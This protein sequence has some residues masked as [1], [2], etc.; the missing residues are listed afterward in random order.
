MVMKEFWELVF[1][2]LLRL[3]KGF[4]FCRQHQ[5]RTLF[6][7]FVFPQPLRKLGAYLILNHERH[8]I[9]SWQG[10]ERLSSEWWTTAFQR[11]YWIVHLKTGPTW[12]I[13]SEASENKP[14][15]FLHGIFD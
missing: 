12:W 5:K 1:H 14:D 9:K 13:F 15:L 7:K 4:Q 8:L 10:P 2:H 11:Q 6:R 3:K